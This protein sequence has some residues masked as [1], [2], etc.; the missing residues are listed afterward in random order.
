MKKYNL[1]WKQQFKDDKGEIF[2]KSYNILIGDDKPILNY[3]RESEE[4]KDNE[5]HVEFQ[6]CM[7]MCATCRVKLLKGQIIYS[8]T[9]IAPFAEDEVLVCSA[10]ARSN[11]ELLSRTILI[12]DENFQSSKELDRKIK[13][14]D[15]KEL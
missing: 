4:H 5:M 3:L 10:F 11:I 2:I 9:T 8:T 13:D 1:I 15:I 14:L 7:G 6:C 12:H